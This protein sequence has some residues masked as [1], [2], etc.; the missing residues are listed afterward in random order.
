MGFKK[1]LKKRLIHIVERY[2]YGNKLGEYAKG[3]LSATK[4]IL[5]IIDEINTK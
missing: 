5:Q 1:K 2:E 3:R 4:M